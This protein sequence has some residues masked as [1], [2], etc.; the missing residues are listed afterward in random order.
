MRP[1]LAVIKDSFVDA[2]R[3]KVLWV[4]IFGWTVL[5]GLIAPFGMIE[6]KSFELTSNEM[7]RVDEIEQQ[8]Q[9][10]IKGQGDPAARRIAERLSEKTKTGLLQDSSSQK[11]FERS[12]RLANALNEVLES[13]D[14][15]EQSAFPRANKKSRLKDLIEIEPSELSSDE[16]GERNRRLI[17]L[18]FSGKIQ[19]VNENKIALGYAGLKIGEELPITKKQFQ[20][21][22]VIAVFFTMKIGIGV[23]A[24]LVAIV[25]T[26]WMIP[27]MFQGGSLHLLLSKPISR[28]LLFLSKFFGGCVFVTLNI[29]YVLAG[30]YLIAGLRFE[31]WN[32]GI[33]RCIPVFLLI[34]II[35][36]SVSALVGVI[37]KNSIVCIVA[38]ALFWGFCFIL[39][40]A[41][42]LFQDILI[43]SQRVS[44]VHSKND[45]YFAS[46]PQ[47]Q[48]RA[49]DRENESWQGVSGFGQQDPAVA[50]FDL[51]KSNE[52]LIVRGSGGN[53]FSGIGNLTLQVMDLSD[54]GEDSMTTTGKAKDAQSEGLQNSKADDDDK[55]PIWSSSRIRKGPSFPTGTRRIRLFDDTLYALSDRGVF[56]FDSSA[57]EVSTEKDNAILNW[58]ESVLPTRKDAFT[59]VTD[60][61]WDAPDPQDFY[62]D[63][64]RETL[65]CLFDGRVQVLTKQNDGLFGTGDREPQEVSSEED[66]SGRLAVSGDHIL[67]IEDNRQPRIAPLNDPEGWSTIDMEEIDAELV[68]AASKPG[69][70]WCLDES[71]HL[72]RIDAEAATA[73]LPAFDGQ[74]RIES[75][76]L[77]SDGRLLI[78]YDV[79]RL[80]IWDAQS[81]N[82]E[83]VADPKQSVMERIFRYA[84]HPLFLINPKPAALDNVVVSALMAD[85]DFEFPGVNEADIDN[86][87]PIW[88]NLLFVSVML[89]VACI[90][91]Y[92]QDL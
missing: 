3:S 72:W 31:I 36:Y 66:F 15:Y 33:L 71:R 28:S 63:T 69:Q 18:A 38:T 44:G 5:L 24:M 73:E 32:T 51:P 67:V 42:G 23:V 21:I 37:W 65:V 9:R 91:L 12:R 82:S 11:N 43:N 41:D 57:L 68:F 22:T 52:L 8:L 79:N 75:L 59:R 77:L 64:S 45:Q 20:N 89:G 87:T 13:E 60:S 46:L 39:G 78:A 55:E 70:F 16:L 14:L 92:K 48:M 56:R 6:E 19:A 4:L 7:L 81:T 76:Q 58:M 40:F 85:G 61:F 17:E 30:L 27:D 86:W 84:I 10:A 74:S 29:V 88:T 25:I 35:F 80:G 1:Y 49:W 90:M 47:G 62:F 83:S 54:T 34:F 50:M 53:P 2:A 26:S